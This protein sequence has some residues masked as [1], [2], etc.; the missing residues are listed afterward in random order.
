[1]LFVYSFLIRIYYLGILFASILHWKSKLFIKYRRN[2]KNHLKE[3][4]LVNRKR[5]LIIAPSIGE[6][7]ECRSFTSRIKKEKNDYQFIYAFHSPSGFEQAKPIGNNFIKMMLP[8]DSKKNAKEL[9]D[10]INPE[11]V[12]L[13]ATGVWPFY[14]Q[15]FKKRN[16]PYYLISF[17]G[18]EHSS[19]FHPLLKKIY[20]PLFSSFTHIFCYTENAKKLIYKNFECDNTTVIGNLRF[21]SIIEMKQNLR[22]IKGIKE[23]VNDCFCI[24]AGSTEKKEDQLL[25]KAFNNLKHQNIKWIIVPHEKLPSALNRLKKSFREDA[26]FYSKGLDFSKNVLIYDITGDLF[27]LYAHADISLVGRGFEKKEIHNMIEPAVYLKPILIGPEHK[28][29]DEP[30]LF[31]KKKFAFEFKNEIELAN[32]IQKLYIG[33]IRVDSS[34][35][36]TIF[37]ENSKGTDMVFKLL[38]E[39]WS[40]QKNTSKENTLNIPKTVTLEKQLTPA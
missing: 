26:C 18:W 21:D 5:I 40:N 7:Q 32:L 16:I 9:L 33:E 22:T 31:I 19:L 25:A 4:L 8:M 14:T 15:E 13:L 27:Q 1:M 3:K 28:R 38:N 24:V 30:K 12:Y 10:L 6:Y 20:K 35:I 23:F 34:A 29:F 17:Q 2:W 11:E 36:Q 39:Q 37:N